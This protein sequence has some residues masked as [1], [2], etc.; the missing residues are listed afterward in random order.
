MQKFL[1]HEPFSVCVV[2]FTASFM[3]TSANVKSLSIFGP[4]C[5]IILLVYVR[6]KKKLNSNERAKRFGLWKM[7]SFDCVTH[8]IFRKIAEIKIYEVWEKSF[9]NWDWFA[10]V[11][12]KKNHVSEPE[13][14]ENRKRWLRLRDFQLFCY[15]LFFEIFWTFWSFFFQ[16]FPKLFLFI[17]QKSCNPFPRSYKHTCSRF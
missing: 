16:N 6:K 3:S 14:K 9:L 10:V 7:Q 2:K 4:H 11:S 1:S 17:P 15:E 5:S 13:A 8:V 12:C